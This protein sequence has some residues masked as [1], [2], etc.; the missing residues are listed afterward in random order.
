M[1]PLRN[2]QTHCP[3]TPKKNA[4]NSDQATREIMRMWGLDKKTRLEAIGLLIDE[5][6]PQKV[7]D[8]CREI[9]NGFASLKAL[10]E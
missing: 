7:Y 8:Y 4:M 5:K 3:P 10:G 9:S 2:C 1:K 6:T